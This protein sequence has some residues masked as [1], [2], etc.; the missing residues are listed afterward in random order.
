MEQLA[1]LR[2]WIYFAGAP[3][4]IQQAKVDYVPPPEGAPQGTVEWHQ[5]EVEID[6]LLDQGKWN[7]AKQKIRLT[8]EGNNGHY[9]N[10]LLALRTAE[11]HL[12][13]PPISIDQAFSTQATR[14][15][16]AAVAYRQNSIQPQLSSA[17]SKYE[18]LKTRRS[19]WESAYPELEQAL[20]TLNHLDNLWWWQKR[21]RKEEIDEAVTRTR[22]A[23]ANCREIA[24]QHSNLQGIE[25]HH[26]LTS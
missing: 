8:V 15:L 14:L 25:S 26:L 7:E 11:Q 9:N 23:L 22:A 17:R 21:K 1:E 24:P 19:R 10:E 12:K 2:T 18:E 3:D 5:V 20:N 6:T 13:T 4:L 16:Q